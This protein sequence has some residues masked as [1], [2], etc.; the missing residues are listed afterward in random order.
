MACVHRPRGALVG[1]LLTLLLAL[2][3]IAPAQPVAAWVSGQF[4]GAQESL[5]FS[6]TNQARAAAG[7][8]PVR[9]NTSLRT[10]A[11]WRS[12]DM[13]VRDY[14][15]HQIPPDGKTV[16]AYLDQKG[17]KYRMAGENI[18]WNT[19]PDNDATRYMQ[20]L[21]MESPGHR[22]NLVA[23]NWDSAGIGAFKGTDGEIR[24]TVLF[25]QS[26][27][28]PSTAPRTGWQPGPVADGAPLPAGPTAAAVAGTPDSSATMAGLD[29]PGWD[30]P[31]GPD[32]GLTMTAG[33][34][35]RLRS[36]A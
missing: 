25:M 1:A 16:F 4:N 19:A 26:A 20:K 36:E 11:R 15:S 13:A 35:P 29:G 9:L 17:I 14:F 33:Y 21:F 30:V 2:S 23:K 27:K 12:Q 18:G 8:P 5:L 3:F 31:P 24:Y 22:S 34:V 6:L 32:D 7:V 10:V 28:K